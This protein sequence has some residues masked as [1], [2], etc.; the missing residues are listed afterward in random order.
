MNTSS[1]AQS[2]ARMDVAIQVE[3]DQE[4]NCVYGRAGEGRGSHGG[5]AGLHRLPSG[6]T[7]CRRR[8]LKSGFRHQMPVDADYGGRRSA[9]LASQTPST[10]IASPATMTDF[11]AVLS[12]GVPDGL[13]FIGDADLTTR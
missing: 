7:D 13:I 1:D 3:R 9:R 12:A 11:E 2:D 8:A 4:G 10:R 6:G 5:R